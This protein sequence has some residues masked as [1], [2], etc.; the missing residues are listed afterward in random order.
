MQKIQDFREKVEQ[1]EALYAQG[2]IAEAEACFLFLRGK[3]PTNPQVLNNLGVIY[4]VS[5]R[6]PEAERCFLDA[7]SAESNAT[8]ALLNL[9]DLYLVNDRL[10]EAIGHLKKGILSDPDNVGLRKRLASVCCDSDRNHTAPQ[11]MDPTREPTVEKDTRPEAPRF[12]G[13]GKQDDSADR[14]RVRAK[15]V[16]M[17]KDDLIEALREACFFP[18][19]DLHTGT[20]DLGREIFEDDGRETNLVISPRAKIDLT[21]DISIGAWT[22]IGDSTEILTHDHFHE[23]RGKPLLKI[24]EEKGIRWLNK[25]IGRD[26][27]LHG[28]TVLYQVTHIPEGVVVGSGAVLT[29]NPGPYEIWAGNPAKKI[30]ER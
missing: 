19:P 13:A 30:G 21:G 11:R 9:V 4:H 15:K 1:G 28:C 20:L 24:Q 26:V 5:G 25:T 18:H 8:D 23:G 6:T 27:W 16:T 10:Q 2:R 17:S 29:K 14:S 12:E 3:Y 22:M 7:I